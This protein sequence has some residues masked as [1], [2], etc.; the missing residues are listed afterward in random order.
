M[1]ITYYYNPAY[2]GYLR[3]LKNIATHGGGISRELSLLAAVE[4]DNMSP[5]QAEHFY[6]SRYYDGSLKKLR[7]SVAQKNK[8]MLEA[9]SLFLKASDV[10]GV[11][12]IPGNGS[13][14][15]PLY[16]KFFRMLRALEEDCDLRAKVHVW[17][18]TDLRRIKSGLATVM[19]SGEM[20]AS[21]QYREL[22]P[23]SVPTIMARY[24][25]LLRER[26]GV[27]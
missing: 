8:D 24:E 26:Q 5:E 6:D 11:P 4:A 16:V 3:E 9:W 10:L 20:L 17:A 19:P 15:K 23:L 14:D 13:P 25:N 22:K 12:R 1:S 7:E 18:N 2:E 21:K 27:K